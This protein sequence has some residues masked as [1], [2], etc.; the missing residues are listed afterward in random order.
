MNQTIRYIAIGAVV[1]ALAAAAWVWQQDDS[2][3]TAGGV[4]ATCVP[5][6]IILY[7]NVD[8]R[9]VNL[10]F[11][12]SG[13]VD[14]LQVEE[15][16]RVMP[17]QKLATLEKPDFVD[18]VA[19]AQ[20]RFDASAAALNQLEN[21]ARPQE[22]AQ[23]EA[24]VEERRATVQNARRTV[25]R[26]AE[27]AEE[28]FTAHQAHEDAEAALLEAEARL[29]SAIET[30]NL[31]KAGP[32]DEEIER[33]RAAHGADAAA[34][35][36]AQRRLADT[37]LFAPNEGT[38]LTRVRE[39]GAIIQAGEPIL[40]LSLKSPVWVRTYVEE[41][42]LGFVTPGMKATVQTDSGGTFEGQ[43]GFIS[44]VAEFTPKTVET[45]ELRTRLVYRVRVIVDSDDDGLRQGMPVTVVL[46]PKGAVA[47]AAAD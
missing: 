20:A 34:L 23:A 21:G 37:D 41:P 42:Q 16:D 24:L 47:G 29:Q 2:V 14:Q 46:V 27:L 39:P 43:V 30:L 19:L 10:G 7:G 25:K 26:R 44:P 18:D 38:I 13:R 8:V 11:K 32:R 33:A 3:C 45:R 1:A 35:S 6:Q 28:G 15:G 36:L 4:P 31:V 5:E 40:N 17:G 12:V 9:Q 22:I